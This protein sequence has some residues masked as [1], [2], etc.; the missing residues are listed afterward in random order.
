MHDR[1]TRLRVGPKFHQ[2]DS[3]PRCAVSRR[4]T[5][6]GLGPHPCSGVD[7]DETS[8]GLTTQG[9]EARVIRCSV[10]HSSSSAQRGGYGP[11][12]RYDYRSGL[13]GNSNS[14]VHSIGL[15]SHCGLQV[16]MPESH[17][18]GGLHMRLTWSRSDST[19]LCTRPG[20]TQRINLGR[21]SVVL[22]NNHQVIYI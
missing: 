17:N 20:L 18:G 22:T 10:T 1:N 21:A 3:H 6:M 15:Q 12:G 2:A 8:G 13:Q 19:N 7:P 4:R 16:P 14:T 9:A 5:P 11:V